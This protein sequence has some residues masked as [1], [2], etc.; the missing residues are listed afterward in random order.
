MAPGPKLSISC[1]C[2]AA[3]QIVHLRDKLPNTPQD[4]D[5]CHCYA[6]RHNTG[7]LCV[8]YAGIER[9]D[10]IQGLVEYRSTTK[11]ITR[12]FCATCG[13]HVF[14]RRE[15][16]LGDSSNAE[17]GD[18]VSQGDWWAVA[19]GVIEGSEEESGENDSEVPIRYA[20][21]INTAGTKDGGL[22]PFIQSIE[23]SREVEVA[24]A[25]GAS[26]SS[27]LTPTKTK[28]SSEGEVLNAFCHCK[29]VRFHITRPNAASKL[30]RSNFADLI[31]PY[32]TGSPQIQNPEDD[33][34]WLRPGLDSAVKGS[35]S[36]PGEELGPRRYLAGTCACRSCRLISGFEIQTWAFVPRANIFFHLD[37]T[38]SGASEEANIVPLD[39]E[40]LPPNILRS[41]ES[42]EGVRREFCSHCG[43]T[44]FWR[45]RWRPELIDVSVGLLDAAEGAR[46]DTWLDWWT[47][48]VSFA[49]DAG[50]GKTGETAR[51]AI[52]L[53]DSLEEGLKRWGEERQKSTS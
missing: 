50:L 27:I 4:I 25:L 37:K 19:T 8:S 42:R 49:E 18:D 26:L 40:A 31:V 48:R 10:S 22:S 2:G 14:W 12:F 5:L 13:C 7:L 41:Y 52:C 53:I 16:T 3:K 45:D 15:I 36:L 9:P 20:K 30:P 35:K 32:K 38:T 17:I 33:K 28:E 46:A 34:W 1:H 11:T 21:H 47:G 24:E 23:G 39:F 51:R 29:T 43:A 44:V 6:C